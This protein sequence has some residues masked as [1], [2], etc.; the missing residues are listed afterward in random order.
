[1]MISAISSFLLLRNVSDSY[2]DP[3]SC[4]YDVSWWYHTQAS[5]YHQIFLNAL[6]FDRVDDTQDL[7][8]WLI[9]FS[10]IA[11]DE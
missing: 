11:I 8:C 9:L 2:F 5:A 4:S 10:S 7:C 1:M 3:N 6:H